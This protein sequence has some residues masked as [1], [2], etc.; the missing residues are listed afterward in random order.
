MNQTKSNFLANTYSPFPVTLVK[1]KGAI[2]QDDKGKEYI[3]LTSGIAVN[4]FGVADSQWVQ[5]VITQLETLTHTSNLYHTQPAQQLA[6]LLCQKTGMSKVFFSNSG[7]EANEC[8]IKAAR[9]YAAQTL[10]KDHV[11]IVTLTG[12]FHGRT[13]ATLAATGQEEYHKLFQPL[14]EGFVHA[15]AGDISD[16]KKILQQYPCAAILLEPVQGEGGVNALDFTYLQQ[17]EALAKQ[18]NIL[19]MVDEVQCGNGRTGKLY[20]Y[21]HSG[22]QPNII[23]TAKG[24]A[25][26]LPLGATL[27][28]E[29]TAEVF[30]AGDHG[31]TFGGNPVC[32]AAAIHT[33]NE[34][35]P[36]FLDGVTHKTKIIQQTL[37]GKKGIVSLSGL[38]LMIGVETQADATE[39]VNVCIQ[40]GV[41][42][43]KVKNKIRLLP[44]LNISEEQLKQALDIFC[45][46]VSNQ[47]KEKGE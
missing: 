28:D 47:T 32:C 45:S 11:Y 30:Q 19:L 31:S 3:D 44:P 33:L 21:M 24:L 18:H 12:S 8:A 37:Q 6:E 4:T 20:G 25:G 36:E 40:Q 15:K 9:K 34:L 5:V 29:K 43:L 10:G 38:G 39:I 7:A 2:L 1:G 42:V 14:P 35:S 16:L 46:V 23:I 13:L 22:I 27:F 41:L 26:G 17:V